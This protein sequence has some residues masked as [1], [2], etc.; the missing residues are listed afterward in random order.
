MSGT[1]SSR[2]VRPIFTTSRQPA[3]FSP[4]ASRSA[5]TDGIT[6]SVTA[7]TAATCIAVGNVSFDDCPMLT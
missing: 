7:S 6:D 1:A 2:C 3:A 4:M 5:V